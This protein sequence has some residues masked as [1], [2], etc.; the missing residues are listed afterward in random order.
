MDAIFMSVCVLK[1]GGQ[2][3]VIERL[4]KN[5]AP[6]FEMA[7]T[8]FVM[9]ISAHCYKIFVTDISHFI[10]MSELRDK[11][12]VLKNFNYARYAVDVTF[13]Q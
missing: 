6:T 11:S 13:Q 10:T 5:K 1:H 9:L 8:K 12:Q 3:N 7:I 4:F 2:L